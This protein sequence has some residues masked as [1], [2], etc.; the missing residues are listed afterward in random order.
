[1]IINI[2]ADGR[3]ADAAPAAPNFPGPAGTGYHGEDANCGFFDD[4]CAQRGGVG[5]NGAP[6]TEGGPGGPGGH[7]GVIQIE[8]NTFDILLALSAK[9]G[10]GGDGGRG[11]AGQDGGKGGSG[12]AG[13]DCEY[14]G[15]G[16]D[17]GPGGTAGVGG[18]GGPGGNG[19]IITLIARDFIN[20]GVTPFMDVSGGAGGRGG[21]PGAVGQGGWPGDA[22]PSTGYFDPSS[23][24][25]RRT[26][27]GGVPG[28]TP[29]PATRGNG[30]DGARGIASR[31]L[32]P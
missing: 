8:A 28:I 16:G 1:M 18:P 5:L 25:D 11:G 10:K 30:P 6:G 17:G 24:C 26:P 21:D 27:I 32:A 12:G 22:G 4:D 2:I 20:D 3:N 14:G 31:R 29:F 19:G 7:A 15:M 23:D 13:E 9:G